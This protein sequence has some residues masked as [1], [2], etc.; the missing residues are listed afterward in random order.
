[1]LI[2]NEDEIARLLSPADALAA[3]RDAFSAQAA[4]SLSM[5]LR[6]I[7]AGEHGMLGAMPAAL[8]GSTAT[9][10]AKLV[11]LFPKNGELGL[12]THNAVIAL[13]D[14]QT[15]RPQALLDG[16][17]ITEI[18]TAATSALATALLARPEA[19]T[20]A[21]LGTGVQAKAHIQALLQVM[22]IDELRIWGRNAHRASAL[23]SFAGA[24]GLA[25]RTFET[26]ASACR[27]ADVICTVTM[28]REPVLRAADVEPG[29]HV[30]AVGFGGPQARELGGDLIAKASIFIDSEHGAAKE[31]GNLHLARQDGHL[32]VDQ[33]LT[34]LCD[35]LAGRT[36]GRQHPDE[37]TV[38]DS[39]GIA[40]EDLACA[41]LVYARALEAGIGTV[42]TI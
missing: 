6:T 37:I 26:L 27:G 1:M 3:M 18:R 42:V 34:L 24:L 30:N 29:T 2:L 39:L 21:I 19:R 20:L 10:G 36:R 4:G 12:P 22:Q 5:P 23:A 33:K 16:R 17:Y 25:T 28:A 9:I 35:V 7:A 8:G 32:R 38:F 14:P 40:I 41:R 11:T 15:G 31:S 13:F